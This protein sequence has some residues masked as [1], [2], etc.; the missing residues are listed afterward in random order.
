MELQMSAMKQ[1]M[2]MVLKKIPKDTWLTYVLPNY[3]TNIGLLSEYRIE[4]DTV[5]NK[6]H[7]DPVATD[8]VDEILGTPTLRSVTTQRTRS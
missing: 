7:T 5:L 6:S 8:A 1:K 3:N 2:S 4:V